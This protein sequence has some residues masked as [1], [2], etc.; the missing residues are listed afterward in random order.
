MWPQLAETFLC[1]T[2]A[3]ILSDGASGNWDHAE[4]TL[5]IDLVDFFVFFLVVGTADF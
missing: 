5:A 1:I 4:L 3:I 2:E